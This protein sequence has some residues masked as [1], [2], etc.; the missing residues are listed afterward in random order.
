MPSIYWNGGKEWNGEYCEEGG[1]G[2]RAC[3]KKWMVPQSAMDISDLKTNGKWHLN[4]LSKHAGTD[5]SD[6]GSQLQT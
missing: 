1:E 5:G 3:R 2:W 6:I 4:W